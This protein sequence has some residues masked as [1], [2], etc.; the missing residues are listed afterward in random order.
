MLG[1]YESI[2]QEE[3]GKGV[4]IQQENPEQEATST[5]KQIVSQFFVKTHQPSVVLDIQSYQYAEASE[6][7]F[8]SKVDF[9]QQ[10]TK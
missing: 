6:A 8:K 2:N 7:Q 4:M 3:I 10:Y 9:I 5:S 1:L